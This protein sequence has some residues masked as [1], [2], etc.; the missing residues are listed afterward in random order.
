MDAEHEALALITTEKD[1]ARMAGDPSL[2]ALAA[3][4]HVLPVRMEIAE[5]DELQ[6]AAMAAVRRAS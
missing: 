6:K 1:H 5:A 3:K 4:S 2:A